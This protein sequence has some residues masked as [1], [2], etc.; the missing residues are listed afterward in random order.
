MPVFRPNRPKTPT[1]RG[2][3]YL[4][5]LYKGV[6]PPPL[7][8]PSGGLSY[9]CDASCRLAEVIEIPSP[10]FNFFYVRERLA[11][12]WVLKRA[13]DGQQGVSAVRGIEIPKKLLYVRFKA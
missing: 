11:G 5:S 7:Q 9:F 4:Y 8:A 13:R 12:N 3:T 1:R 10:F 6:P 2:G